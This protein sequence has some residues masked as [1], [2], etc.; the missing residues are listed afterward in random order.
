MKIIKTLINLWNLSKKIKN[1]KIIITHQ[2]KKE[3]VHQQ[4]SKDNVISQVH[5]YDTI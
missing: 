4:N 2:K 5:S 1:A 3:N